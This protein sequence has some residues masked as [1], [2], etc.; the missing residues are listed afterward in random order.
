M[1][2]ERANWGLNLPSPK[3]IC[4]NL[5]VAAAGSFNFFAVFVRI[6]TVQTGFTRS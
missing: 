5:I 6:F 1:P 4:G 3:S 2:I